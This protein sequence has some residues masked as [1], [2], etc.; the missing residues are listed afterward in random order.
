[1][2][3]PSN[4]KQHLVSSS[5]R[6]TKEEAP[7]SS[8]SL[9][10]CTFEN[11]WFPKNAEFLTNP[12]AC[13]FAQDFPQITDFRCPRID[14][15]PIEYWRVVPLMPGMACIPL[16]GEDSV[17]GQGE[18]FKPMRFHTRRLQWHRQFF[19]C[20]F[21]CSGYLTLSG[22]SGYGLPGKQPARFL[23]PSTCF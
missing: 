7:M 16:P 4:S 21:S 12:P 23:I 1:M 5:S 18:S 11:R 9:F 19:L 2:L 22:Q 8:V 15:F 20:S 10:H 3:C 13:W 6:I 14:P 17:S